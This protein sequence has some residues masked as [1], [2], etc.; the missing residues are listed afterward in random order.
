MHTDAPV[1]SVAKALDLLGI[2]VFED[3][4]RLGWTVG[5]LAKRAGLPVST[6]HS[7]LRSLAC[8]G[9][10]RQLDRG[11][12]A[13]GA[14]VQAIGSLNRWCDP[15]VLQRIQDRLE[16]CATAAGEYCNCSILQQGRRIPVAAAAAQRTVRI[17]DRQLEKAPFFA[18]TSGRALY[19]WGDEQQ[20]Q[21]IRRA[22]GE[23]A[24]HW[25]GLTGAALEAACA[26]ARRQGLV[27]RHLE[28]ACSLAVPVGDAQGR[29]LAVIGCHA[30]LF[31]FRGA[32][33]QRVLQELRDCA[34][35]IAA[36]W[37]DPHVDSD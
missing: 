8:C 4:R 7:L 32:S 28:E 3:R 13:V 12:Y 1:R 6:T 22:H 31:R 5:E 26:Q 30:P 2:L 27:E 29:L 25:D 14:A 16:A 36:I 15:L 33:R 17:D 35:S 9:W 21:D 11:L 20:R 23:A 10:V 34:A 18:L 24:P 19:I 37:K